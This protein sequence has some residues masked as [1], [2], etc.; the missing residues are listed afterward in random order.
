M[1]DFINSSLLSIN[2]SVCNFSFS[3]I[4]S[5]RDSYDRYTLLAQKDYDI[6]NLSAIVNPDSLL[7]GLAGTESK[8][9][10]CSGKSAGP[11]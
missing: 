1:I 3:L 11:F 4:R 2:L 9:M 10:F 8:F 5:S 7:L 6:L